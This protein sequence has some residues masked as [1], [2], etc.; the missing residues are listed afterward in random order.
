MLPISYKSEAAGDVRGGDTVRRV[1]EGGG[2]GG[3]GSIRPTFGWLADWLVNKATY[4]SMNERRISGVVTRSTVLAPVAL[5][6]G[7][8]TA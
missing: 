2:G 4:L 7:Q 5:T 6:D 8:V 3:G 1:E